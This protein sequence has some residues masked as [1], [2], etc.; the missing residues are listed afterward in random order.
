[1]S[2]FSTEIF[3]D[4]LRK[5]TDT[6]D[7]ISL[8]SHSNSRQ[9]LTYLHLA[10]DVLQAS[11]KKGTEY[12]DEFQKALVDVIKNFKKSAP[13]ALLTRMKRVLD[14]WEER[15]VYDKAFVHK[16]R[17]IL[18][19]RPGS[20][21]VKPTYS[22]NGDSLDKLIALNGQ[23][24][25]GERQNKHSE[26]ICIKMLT[27]LNQRLASTDP[28]IE[29]I[30][31]KVVDGWVKRHAYLKAHITKRQQLIEVLQAT[32]ASQQE[33]LM[34]NLTSLQDCE[35][36]LSHLAPHIGEVEGDEDGAQS[37]TPSQSSGI[38]TP[39]D[40]LKAAEDTTNPPP[41]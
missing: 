37:G 35:L 5:L 34:E 3:K 16:L 30:L 26:E 8:L 12:R 40:K 18:G 7:S 38:A 28:S 4:K 9:Q 6:Q 39:G 20:P 31:P 23:V 19:I 2:K 21:S 11:R 1:M 32:L 17:D 27:E 41:S 33:K 15:A 24:S 22:K 25:L 14:V 36:S 13:E 29:D 10:N